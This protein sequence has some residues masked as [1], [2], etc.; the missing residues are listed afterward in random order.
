MLS[1]IP[2]WW[3]YL[4]AAVAIAVVLAAAYIYFGPTGFGA[5]GG[6]VGTAYLL[7][8]RADNQRADERRR[9]VREA[10][11]PGRTVS[12][13]TTEVLANAEADVASKT[14]LELLKDRKGDS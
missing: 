1:T 2:R 10:R 14:T 7:A 8:K 5:V 12:R 13:P 4:G 6:G 3:L 11:K 9:K